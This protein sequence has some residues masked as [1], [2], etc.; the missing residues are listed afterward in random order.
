MATCIVFYEYESETDGR[1]EDSQ[2]FK[3]MDKAVDEYSF[4]KGH[5][6]WVA[7]QVDGRVVEEFFR[8]VD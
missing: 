4:R 5:C 6:S 1:V 3:A 7:L 2:S 8:A